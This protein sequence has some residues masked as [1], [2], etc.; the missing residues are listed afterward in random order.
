[1]GGIW[2][3]DAGGAYQPARQLYVADDNGAFRPAKAGWVADANGVFQPLALPG[4]SS[5][6]SFTAAKVSPTYR[7]VLVQWSI[8]D[9]LVQTWALY[10]TGTANP[11]ATGRV[12]D[13]EF[14]TYSGTPGQKYGFQLRCYRADGTYADSSPA[15]VTLDSLPAPANFRQSALSS[16]SSTWS[17]NGVTGATGYDLVDTL[18][19]GA[20]VKWSGTGS[21]VAESGLAATTTYERAVRSKLAGVVSP[22]SNKIR[23]TTPKPAGP[24]AGTYQYPATAGAVWAPGRNAWRPASDGVIHGNGDVWGASNGNQGTV[25]LYGN[26]PWTALRGGRVTRFKIQIHRDSAAGYSSAQA[27]RFWL[28]N[29][30]VRPAGAPGLYAALDAGSESWGDNNLID[31]PIAWAQ[32]M[33]DDGVVG[34][35]GWGFVGGRY[36]RGLGPA[37]GEPLQGKLLITIG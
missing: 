27:N 29:Y 35:I 4:A 23:Y 16:T 25:F 6:G 20:P 30:T 24:A 21:S 15:T 18:T 3:P 37:N 32:H 5:L 9:S 2:L 17:W 19:A 1:M 11:I 33:V 7:D 13:P 34:G 22:V 26:R 14:F 31:L 8:S 36:M 12:S 28:H 10:L